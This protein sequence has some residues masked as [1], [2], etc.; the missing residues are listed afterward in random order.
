MSDICGVPLDHKFPEDAVFLRGI[1]IIQALDPEG[2]LRL[3]VSSTG[4][5]NNHEALDLINQVRD[6]ILSVLEE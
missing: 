2:N 6:R 4:S 3:W 1:A 5:V